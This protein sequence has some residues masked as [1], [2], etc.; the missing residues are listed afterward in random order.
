MMVTKISASK[1]HGRPARTH[2]H[3]HAHGSMA[4]LLRLKGRR[5]L[6]H[7]NA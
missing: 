4:G 3:A 1:R 5:L 6:K 2:A 7:G